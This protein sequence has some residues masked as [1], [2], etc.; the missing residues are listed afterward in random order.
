VIIREDAIQADV[1][2][3]VR[4]YVAREAPL[5]QVGVWER[6]GEYPAAFFDGLAHLGYFGVH[7]PEEQGG[8]GMG[9]AAM[10]IIG[11]E[12][13]RGGL[14]LAVGYGLQAFPAANLCSYGT[15]AQ[16]AAHLPRV[17]AHEAR[18]A[19]G[20]S[21]PD[22][23]SDAAAVRTSAR[24]VPGGFVVS[25][26]KLWTS[27]AGVPNTTLQTLVRTEP[28][29]RRQ[30]GLAVVLVPLD[31]P[32][33]TLR[34]LSTVGRHLLGTYEVFLDDVEVGEDAVLGGPT[35][36]WAV[37]ASSLRM[38]RIFAAAELAGCARTSL[39]LTVEYVRQRRQFGR[40]IGS[41]QTVAHTLAELHARL[42]AAR[43]LVYRAAQDLDDGSADFGAGS[44]AKLLCSAL[45]QEITQHGMQFLGG[46]GYTTEH[47]MERLW[48]EARS[49]TVSGGTSEIQRTIIARSL[50]L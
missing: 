49:V 3:T 4:D 41:F 48:R 20:I 8:G 44:G 46:V 13:G 47:P 19:V 36:G 32:G 12:L 50:G 43:L 37:M 30:D 1:R 38:E 16:I 11:E 10:A 22:A 27:G 21:E 6:A 26:Q 14:E 5:E 42:E 23:G 9:A 25:G 18:F 34:R 39:D 2:R 31:A 15:S 35:E 45:F 29:E 24:R 33:V 40:P 28:A 7:L 17:L